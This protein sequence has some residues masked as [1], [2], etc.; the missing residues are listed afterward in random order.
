MEPELRQQALKAFTKPKAAKTFYET[1]A[2]FP[3]MEQDATPYVYEEQFHNQLK[4]RLLNDMVLTQVV[5]ESTIGNTG[6]PGAEGVDPRQAARQ[7]EIAW[8]LC[9][10][11]FYKVG[12]RPWKVASIRDGVCYRSEEHT[13]ELQSLRHLVC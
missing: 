1:R 5:R 10:A 8:N 12:G 4:A 3:E 9:T 11:V 6:K 7:S 13:S 2:L